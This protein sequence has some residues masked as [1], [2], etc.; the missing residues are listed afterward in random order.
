VYFLWK[1]YA[2]DDTLPQLTRRGIIG[3]PQIETVDCGA[4]R[5]AG[6]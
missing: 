4:E 5:S 1:K 2:R 3:A 6:G